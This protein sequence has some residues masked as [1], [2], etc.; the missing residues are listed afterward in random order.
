MLKSLLAAMLA[1]RKISSA[2][3]SKNL[4]RKYHKLCRPLKYCHRINKSSSL[5]SNL[6]RFQAAIAPHILGVLIGRHTFSTS[7]DRSAY[8]KLPWKDRYLMVYCD[9]EIIALYKFF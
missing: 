8:N 3:F 2:C 5:H 1:A 9:H 4:S 6:D 7:A